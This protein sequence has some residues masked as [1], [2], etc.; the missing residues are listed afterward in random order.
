MRPKDYFL[1]INPTAR[2]GKAKKTYRKV[3]GLLKKENADFD[4]TLT[5]NA[6]EAIGLAI[7]ATEKGYK[8]IVAVGGDG[9]I[10]ETINGI[11]L[12][13]KPEIK[14]KLGVIHT[15]TSPDFNKHHNIPVKIECAI[16]T[17]ISK[18]SRLIDLCRVEYYN[19]P[20][21]K[22]KIVSYY[23]SNANIGLG[24]L[25]AQKA[26]CRY[27]KYLGDTLGTLSAMLISL[28]KFPGVNLTIDIDGKKETLK[29]IIN[30]TIGKDPYLAS[31][32]RIFCD[33]AGNDGRMFIL[34]IK[35]SPLYRLISNITGLYLGN[36]LNQKEAGITYAQKVELNTDSDYALL[37]FD[38]DVRGY[39][40]AL[41]TV[42]PNKL[43]VITDS[44]TIKR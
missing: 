9:T 14:P 4:Y 27:R 13:K 23:A 21:K 15:G 11:L 20:Q 29:G 37:E 17:L 42:L 6:N 36:I 30:L 39:L 1:I 28:I 7:T 44:F 19:D 12:A 40:P 26:N 2:S 35:K 18:K 33:I 22:E 25:I 38:G 10:C 5:T 43:E 41:I 32:M 16:K 34:Y 3:L 24:P 31:G 8:T